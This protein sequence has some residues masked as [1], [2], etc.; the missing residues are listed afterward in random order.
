MNMDMHIGEPIVK[1]NF[2]I[3]FPLFQNKINTF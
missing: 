2:K 3:L 1:P